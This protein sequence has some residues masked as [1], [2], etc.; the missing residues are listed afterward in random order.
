MDRG[1]I[2]SSHLFIHALQW[3][4]KTTTQKLT[5]IK[6]QLQ[7]LHL[8]FSYNSWLYNSM[9]LP[10]PQTSHRKSLRSMPWTFSKFNWMVHENKGNMI[11]LTSTHDL[12]AASSNAALHVSSATES[13]EN[14]E[15][16]SS[17][18]LLCPMHLSNS[19]KAS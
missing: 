18:P 5:R 8:A 7:K 15:A 6:K 17:H 11:L 16:A 19:K 3:H 12:P 13:P 2:H 9:K 14:I 10:S 4:V 1:R